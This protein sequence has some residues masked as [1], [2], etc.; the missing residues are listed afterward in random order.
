MLSSILYAL[1]TR[2][3]TRQPWLLIGI[4]G[5]TVATWLLAGASDFTSKE[6]L[7]WLVFGWGF[8]VG[9][10]PMPMLTNEVEG[11]KLRDKPYAATVALALYFVP[12]LTLPG[13]ATVWTADWRA[14]AQD[15]Q[16]MSIADDRPE[17][18][19]V[20]GRVADYYQKVGMQGPELSELTGQVI[21][22]RVGIDSVVIGYQQ[23]MRQIALVI[24]GIGLVIGVLLRTPHRDQPKTALLVVET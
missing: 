9:M 5:S 2:R 22:T 16:R 10:L 24:G 3:A 11:L 20:S 12:F 7:T 23:A 19:N 17:M 15:A 1:L 13:M 18:A 21:A 8:F 4:A 6:H 14:R